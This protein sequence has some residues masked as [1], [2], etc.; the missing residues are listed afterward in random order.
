MVILQIEILLR[1]KNYINDII[2]ISAENAEFMVDAT[3]RK[4]L[5]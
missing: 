4:L 1:L 2:V 3:Y 5:N